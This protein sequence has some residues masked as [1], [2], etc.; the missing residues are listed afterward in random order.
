MT[1]LAHNAWAVFLRKNERDKSTNEGDCG[2][3][4]LVHHGAQKIA[5][6]RTILT[7]QSAAFAPNWA[8]SADVGNSARSAEFFCAPKRRQAR[9]A[10]IA[11]APQCAMRRSAVLSFT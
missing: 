6:R 2:G 7:P 8:Q 9:V 3:A 1:A 11:G 4:G 10:S 5:A